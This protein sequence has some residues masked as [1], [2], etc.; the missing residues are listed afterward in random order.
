MHLYP[1]WI[2]FYTNV[3]FDLQAD[4]F[5]SSYVA[6]PLIQAWAL[7]PL[8]TTVPD[9]LHKQ[10]CLFR[11]PCFLFLEGEKK[12]RGQ[13][14]SCAR[15]RIWKGDR[16]R[17]WARCFLLMPFPFRRHLNIYAPNFLE[18]PGSLRW[19]G[20]WSLKYYGRAP[21]FKA[22]STQH[23][24]ARC[25]EWSSPSHRA[26]WETTC[27]EKSHGIQ[28]FTVDS[29]EQSF[30]NLFEYNCPPLF[31]FMECPVASH[32]SPVCSCCCKGMFWVSLDEHSPRLL[33]S[34]WGAKHSMP[35][36]LSKNNCGWNSDRF[37]LS[38]SSIS[39]KT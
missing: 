31:F 17:R 30:P 19:H 2:R 18:Q 11:V 36:P 37:Y 22:C 9:S 8:G 26:R 23:A 12:G 1:F 24:S 38:F 14:G 5:I 35:V 13:Q 10:L 3:S 7:E 6:S 16:D 4:P 34:C 27:S 32:Q 28:K 33:Q 29:L 21:L 15:S 25:S 39:T 20:L